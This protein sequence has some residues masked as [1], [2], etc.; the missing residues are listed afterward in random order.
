[1]TRG[2]L[3]YALFNG[4]GLLAAFLLLRKTRSAAFDALPA[5]DKTALVVGCLAGG[6]LGAK[7]PVLLSYGWS[8]R[9]LW[10]GKSLFG[11]LL[12]GWAGINLAK[13]FLR[14]PGRFGDRFAL[15]VAAAAAIGSLGC[16][17]HGCCGG[18]PT[19]SSFSVLD[20]SGIRVHP[21]QLYTALFQAAMALLL[22]R[23]ERRRLL[24]GARFPLYML[25]Y[26]GFRFLVEFL[27]AE[28]RVAMGLT[29]YQFLGAGSVL[30]FGWTLARRLR[31]VRT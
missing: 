23:M 25:C 20:A 26:G 29:V 6:M 16:L 19:D 15:P 31:E 5:H 12:G 1:V 4:L 22:W 21:T 14:V 10:T 24:E 13:A 9:L 2:L 27:R 30:L 18:L 3:G 17:V 8:P 28:P 11:G 7:L